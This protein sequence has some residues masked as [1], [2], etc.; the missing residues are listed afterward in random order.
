MK[1]N[2]LL[3]IV[4]VIALV[5]LVFNFKPLLQSFFRSRAL[6][7][8]DLASAITTSKVTNVV[9]GD[10]F[11]IETG[12]RVRLA[13]IDAPEYPKGCF[14]LE[15]KNRLIEMVKGKN[16]VMYGGERD[17]FGRAV[18]TVYQDNLLVN[19]ALVSE[20]FAKFSP[21]SS[22]SPYDVMLKQAE[23]EAKN[24]KRGI[25]SSACKQ[26]QVGCVIKG[27]Y[28]ADNNTYIYHLPNC[29]NYDKIVVNEK[30]RDQWFCTELETTKAGF[31][32]S[33][34]CP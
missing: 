20:G 27:N 26:K 17:N 14:S 32:K 15:S 3:V 8:M 19:K 10:T 9:D 12:T 2:L 22:Q 29:Y 7:E 24:A 33:K 6:S 28:R 16:I 34:D 21:K 23:D 11:D 25:W 18:S 5:S 4:G 1:K 31:V 13:F 30:E